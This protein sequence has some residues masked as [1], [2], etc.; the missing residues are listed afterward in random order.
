MVDGNTSYW[1]YWFGHKAAGF[2][3]G[4]VSGGCKFDNCGG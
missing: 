4:T 1:E 2:G 3:V